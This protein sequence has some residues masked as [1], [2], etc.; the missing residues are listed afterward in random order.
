MTHLEPSGAPAAGRPPPQLEGGEEEEE[1]GEEEGEEEE[2]EKEEDYEKREEEEKEGAGASPSLS[3]PSCEAAAAAAREAGGGGWGRA[4]GGRAGASALLLLQRQPLFPLRPWPPLARLS[5]RRAGR[6]RGSLAH[7]LEA[8]EC[9]PGAARGLPAA[10]RGRPHRRPGERASEG[11]SGPGQGRTAAGT[12]PGRAGWGA[13][14]RGAPG[15]VGARAMRGGRGKWEHIM[16]MLEEFLKKRL[17]KDTGES[18]GGE[19]GIVRLNS[20][21]SADEPGVVRRQR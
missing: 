17:S 18:R 20:A 19:A 11:P 13:A 14:V 12:Q 3:G 4:R 6:A 8:R 21:D 5:A 10:S 15:R 9:R 2:A 7:V 1:E 16:Q